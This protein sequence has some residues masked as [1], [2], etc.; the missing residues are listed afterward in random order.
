MRGVSD[1]ERWLRNEINWIGLKWRTASLDQDGE[2]T[3]FFAGM[4]Q[5]LGDVM[6]VASVL[7]DDE[8]GRWV[9]QAKGQVT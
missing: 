3:A 6:S 5:S 9:D 2:Q 7:E 1:L 4:L 8:I